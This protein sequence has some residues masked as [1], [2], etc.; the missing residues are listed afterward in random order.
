MSYSPRK[1]NRKRFLSELV[2]I[3]AWHEP[4]ILNQK[5]AGVF[6]ELSFKEGR[7]G[8]G[9]DELP[10]TFKVSL[11]RA[12]LLVRLEHPLELNRTS[13]ARSIPETQAELT[14]VKTAREEAE[15]KLGGTLEMSPAAF[16]AAI[17]GSA[18]NKVAKSEEL[19]IVQTIPEIMVTP[20]PEGASA[21]SWIM[22]PTWKE[23]LRGQPWDPVDIPR[24]RVGMNGNEIKLPPAV[25][26]ELRCN[27]EDIDVYDLE[28]KAE[29]VMGVVKDQ[30]F[31]ATNRKAAHQHLKKLISEADLIPAKFDNRF[32]EVMLA[33]V[34]AMEGGDEG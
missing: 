19:K 3:D 29:T 18:T 4:I 34:L 16:A 30:I 5:T 28:T 25:S 9:N 32:N 8:G 17:S 15:R 27:F 13:V 31:N 7:I 10:F 33:S 22:E 21:Y 11:R 20:Y 26:V 14:R 6:V 12:A 1:D 24:M 23:H 2:S